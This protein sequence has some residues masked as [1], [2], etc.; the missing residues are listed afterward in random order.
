MLDIIMLGSLIILTTSMVGLIKW[1]N[2]V[3][4][5]GGDK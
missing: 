1:S 5:E 2:K 4:E 3:V